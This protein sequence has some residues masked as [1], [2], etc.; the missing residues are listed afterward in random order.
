MKESGYE[1]A[2]ISLFP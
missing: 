1:Q 2:T